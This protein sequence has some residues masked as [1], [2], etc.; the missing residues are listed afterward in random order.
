VQFI[1]VAA[2]AAGIMNIASSSPYGRSVG[3]SIASIVLG[4][5]LALGLTELMWRTVAR[6]KGS[7]GIWKVK[8][9]EVRVQSVNVRGKRMLVFE[10]V[11]D[12]R[13]NLVPGNDATSR[14]IR[15]VY[16]GWWDGAG[17]ERG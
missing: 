10:L 3:L 6:G 11:V 1:S 14:E 7:F 5:A 17:L 8:I 4:I 16:S 13:E 2:I 15:Y 12:G 9:D